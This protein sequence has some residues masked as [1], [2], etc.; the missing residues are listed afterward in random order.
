VEDPVQSRGIEIMPA[1]S[2][3]TIGILG[4]G[5]RIRILNP[6]EQAGQHEVYELAFQPDGLLDSAPHGPKA[7][8]QLMVIQGY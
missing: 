1:A 8:E 6:P 5:C 7:K 4:E 2:P 3:P